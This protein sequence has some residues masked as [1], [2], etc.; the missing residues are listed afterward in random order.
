MVSVFID[1][2]LKMFLEVGFHSL[3]HCTVDFGDFHK[4]S[5]LQIVQCTGLMHIYMYLEVSPQEIITIAQIRG[6]RG[7]RIS[8]NME[9]KQLL[10]RGW[11]MSIDALAVWV[12]C[13]SLRKPHM[14][15]SDI[16]SS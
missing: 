11:R 9:M 4:N 13:P 14:L 16:F 3:Q 8:A 7:Q 12:G 2:F 15:E 5:F 6:L 10:K 1:A